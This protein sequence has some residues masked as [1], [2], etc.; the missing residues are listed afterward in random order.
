[1]GK[2]CVVADFGCGK[3]KIAAFKMEM[4]S[5]CFI[6]VL[7]QTLPKTVY[8]MLIRCRGLPCNWISSP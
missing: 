2:C 4:V 3:T 5:R 8:L 7:L 1:M 6:A